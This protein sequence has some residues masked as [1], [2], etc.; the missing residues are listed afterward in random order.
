MR[1]RKYADCLGFSILRK[2]RDCWTSLDSRQLTNSSLNNIPRSR[3]S[4]LLWSRKQP[5][6]PAAQARRTGNCER[7]GSSGD[8]LR[9]EYEKRHAAE[10]IGME[11][12]Q[13]NEIDR[14]TVNTQLF[15]ADE[16]RCSAIDQKI[17]ARRLDMK[18]GVEP[19]A[20]SECVPAT[21]KLH[22]H[23]LFPLAQHKTSDKGPGFAFFCK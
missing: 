15:H 4:T 17:S 21:D 6:V 16:G 18:T 23:A 19:P 22:P 3:S 8:E 11:M 2:R 10:V 5:I 14:V 1:A 7:A 13:E 20:G 12:S 9:V